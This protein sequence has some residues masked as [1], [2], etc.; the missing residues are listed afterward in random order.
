MT[1]ID[2]ISFETVKD[3]K[4][5]EYLMIACDEDKASPRLE[6]LRVAKGWIYTMI[7]ENRY[8]KDPAY[9]SVFV[10]YSNVP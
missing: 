4:F 10:P 6:I 8:E 1:H 7:D 9:S 5:H 3:M 2:D